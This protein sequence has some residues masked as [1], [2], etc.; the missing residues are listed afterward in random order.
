MLLHTCAASALSSLALSLVAAAL[1]LP[2]W[3]VAASPDQRTAAQLLVH[4]CKASLPPSLIMYGMPVLYANVRCRNGQD[5]TPQPVLRWWAGQRTDLHITRQGGS[6]GAQIGADVADVGMAMAAEAAGGGA[7]SEGRVAGVGAKEVTW[8]SDPS[9]TGPPLRSGGA[10]QGILEGG[11]S[12]KGSSEG[13]LSSRGGCAAVGPTPRRSG[14]GAVQRH[15][16]TAGRIPSVLWP[17]TPTLADPESA[18]AA[19]RR[20]LSAASTLSGGSSAILPPMPP[21]P[22]TPLPQTQTQVQT[23]APPKSRLS[24]DAAVTVPPPAAGASEGTPAVGVEEDV[25]TVAPVQQAPAVAAL[26]AVANT[27]SGTGYG[28]P[29]GAAATAALPPAVPPP[30]PRQPALPPLR[31]RT[32]HSAS[33]SLPSPLYRSPYPTGAISLSC[34]V[35]KL[36]K[37]FRVNLRQYAWSDGQVIYRPRC[38]TASVASPW[39]SGFY[40][41]HAVRPVAHLQL[42]SCGALIREH[43]LQGR[44]SC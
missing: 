42:A 29:A 21:P 20:G 30:L 6:G 24:P 8:A 27:S 17:S 12:A 15:I 14:S 10:L 13:R 5:G 36:Q 44:H 1:H 25:G 38:C 37:V 39:Q 35:G 23:S 22:Q 3:E 11:S 43:K 32:R 18:G 7:E 31:G 34:K 2:P 9:G 19:A 41:P 33:A 40:C 4:V 26:S 28:Q 16:A